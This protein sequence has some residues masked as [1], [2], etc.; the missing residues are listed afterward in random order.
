MELKDV[1]SIY[2]IGIGGIGMSALAR[3]FYRRGVAVAGYDRT[4]TE[5]TRALAAEG[6]NIRYHEDATTLPPTDLVVYTPAVPAAHAELSYFQGQGYPVY[7]RSEVL[8]LISRGMRAIAIGGTHGKTT[9][10]TLTTHLVRSAGIDASAFLGG[11]SR[12]LGSNF[13]AGLDDLVVVEADEYDRSFLRLDPDI[14]VIMAMDPD[15]LEIYGNHE[16][17][18]ET[19]FRAFARK[20]KPGGKLLL[21]YDLEHYFPASDAYPTP[22]TFGVGGGLHRSDNIRVEDGYFVFDYESPLANLKGLRHPHPGRHNV[23]NATAAITA[24]LI[25]GASPE[26]IQ[27][28]LLTFQGIGRRFEFIIRSDDRIYIDDYAHHPAELEAA[29]GAARQLYPGQKL[30]GVFQPHLYSRTNDLADG[31]AAALDQLDEALLLDIYPA[32]EEPMPGVSSAMIKDRMK[33]PNCTLLGKAELPE[34]IRQRNPRLL[35]TM[36]A[37]DIDTFVEPIKQILLTGM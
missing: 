19:G 13:V 4:E 6:M 32:R 7:K 11:I 18:V 5:L 31:F 17:M 24:A 12:N 14:A 37:G 34:A 3:Y 15:H 10:T 33:N 25:A 23:E 35:L 28:G 21:R 36:G 9:T 26:S 22:E 16:N 20:I 2:F 27:E 8:G 30:T 29:I 1:R